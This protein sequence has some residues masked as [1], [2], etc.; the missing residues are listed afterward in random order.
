MVKGILMRIV[1]DGD[2][3]RS[4]RIGDSERSER[5]GAK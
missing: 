2:S 3:E 5:V 1:G 4:E